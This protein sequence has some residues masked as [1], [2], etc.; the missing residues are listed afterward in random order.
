M[1]GYSIPRRDETRVS[2]HPGDELIDCSSTTT[3]LAG[4]SVAARLLLLLF[5]F[6]DEFEFNRQPERETGNADDHSHRN[7][8]WTKYIAEQV[9]DCV[10]HYRL[11]EKVSM[12]CH[13]DAESDNARDFI[14]R[15]QM[16]F[17]RGETA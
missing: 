16:L 12:S 17:N 6:E 10:R 14:E 13:E 8:L 11:V 15:A 5:Y 9:R 4:V 2:F 1:I 3:L 7:F